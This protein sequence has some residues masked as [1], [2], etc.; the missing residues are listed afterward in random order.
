MDSPSVHACLHTQ[1]HNE[2]SSMCIALSRC[3]VTGVFKNAIRGWIL[4]DA[5][6]SD[7]GRQSEQRRKRLVVKNKKIKIKTHIDHVDVVVIGKRLQH[8][9]D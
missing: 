4:Q 6:A 5:E 8:L 2:D 9:A 7:T 3:K 1:S